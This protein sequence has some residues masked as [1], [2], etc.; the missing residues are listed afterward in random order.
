MGHLEEHREAIGT[1]KQVAGREETVPD[2]LLSPGV[3]GRTRGHY[4]PGAMGWLCGHLS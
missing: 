3:S 1:N 4:T 2:E